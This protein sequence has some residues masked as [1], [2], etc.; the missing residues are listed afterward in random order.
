MRQIPVIL[1]LLLSFYAKSQVF[2][3]TGGVI[4]NNGV[5]TY[6]SLPVSLVQAQLDNNFGVQEVCINISHPA[7]EEL[8]IYL[9]S[10]SG[11]IVELTDGNNC[12]GANYTNTCFSNTAGTSVT[13]GTAPYSGNHKSVGFLGRFNNGQT[14]TGTWNLIVKDYLA[15][16]GAG[17]VIDW[18]IRFS[19]SPVAPLLFASSDL[20]IVVINTSGQTISDVRILASMGI[21]YNGAGV[22]NYM[23]D[24]LNDY[25]GYSKI[26]FRGNS[27]KNFE[28]KPY[29]VETSDAAGVDFAV[30]LLGMP[31][32]SEWVL[33]AMYQDKSLIRVPMTYDLSRKMGNYAARYKTVEVVINNEYQGVYALM[34]KLKRGAERIDVKKLS[35][36]ENAAPAITGG[37]IVK[38]DRA[39]EPGWSSLHPGDAVNNAHFYYQYV[40]PK[41]SI[42]VP[43]MTYIK[44]FVDTF[45]T[46]M[47]YPNYYA[48][49]WAGYQRYIDI[50]SLVD[51]FIINELSKNVDAYRLSTYLYKDK[52]TQG[53]KLHIG[54]VWD[55]DLAWHNCNYSNSFDPTGWQYQLTDTMLPTPIWWT[56]FMQDTSFT[57]TLYCR[58]TQLRPNVLSN[59]ALFSYIDSSAL[60]LNE[61][62]QRNFI[63]WPILGAYIAPNPQNQSGA[64]YQSEVT[65][66]KNWI[67]SRAGWMDGMITGHCP[68]IGV[69]ENIAENNLV[70]Y[71][72]PSQGMFNVKCLQ[73]AAPS[74][75]DNGKTLTLEIYNILGKIL[76]T[77][78]INHQPLAIDFSSQPKGIYFYQLSINNSIKAGKIIIQ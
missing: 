68:V 6:F 30:S 52:I 20:P 40:Y 66:L 9:Q 32:E 17:S 54:P 22:R 29:S 33:V 26:R 60:A 19:N 67:A 41:D 78:T 75:M 55:Y 31:V 58:W 37:Y 73:V 47:S 45:E 16:V 25:N 71:P 59:S 8:Y 51:F 21:I 35:P 13:L 34:E 57:N 48:D 74:G 50:A 76:F 63:Q 14:G 64:T 28:K 61:S 72:N 65:D 1:F 44:A 3:G 11:T 39:D 56:R 70:V 15:F 7:V 49:P 10:P 27:T 53:G 4:Q 43:Q 77:S 46:I 36:L 24:P 38:I 12:K 23:T 2:P 69:E 5:E 42:T 62:Q 18:S